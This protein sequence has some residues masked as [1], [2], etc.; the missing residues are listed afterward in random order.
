MVQEYF[1]GNHLSG[2]EALLK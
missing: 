1:E 2:S